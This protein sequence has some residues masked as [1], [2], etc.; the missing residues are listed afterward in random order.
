[1]RHI[2]RLAGATLT[3]VLAWAILAPVA[4]ADHETR[5][6]DLQEAG[7]I[8]QW[9]FWATIALTVIALTIFAAAIL[10]WER[11][12]EAASGPDSA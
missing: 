2:L 12:D 5:D 6:L 11:R 1:M 9:A 3:A 10:W 8:N 4:L 7:G